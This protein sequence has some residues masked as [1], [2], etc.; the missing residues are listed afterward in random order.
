MPPRYINIWKHPPSPALQSFQ[1]YSSVPLEEMSWL[2]SQRTGPILHLR[3][4][5]LRMPPQQT[6]A[7]EPTGSVRAVVQGKCQVIGDP[8]VGYHV[9]GLAVHG[10]RHDAFQ[11]RAAEM[12]FKLLGIV[13]QPGTWP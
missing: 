10:S 8:L 5:A 4:A 2:G 3:W 9:L 7:E 13:L 11:D 1:I 12:R 6:L